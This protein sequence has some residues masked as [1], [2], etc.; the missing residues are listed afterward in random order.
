MAAGHEALISSW[1]TA[2]AA[3]GADLAGVD[4]VRERPGAGLASDLGQRLATS[5][6]ASTLVHDVNVKP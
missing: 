1:S 2:T 3:A 5:S 4:H 6:R